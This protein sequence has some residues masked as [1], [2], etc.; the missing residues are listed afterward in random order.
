LSE[1][2]IVRHIAT[3]TGPLGACR[4]YLFETVE[5]LTELGIRDRRLETMAARVREY[6]S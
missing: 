6:R 4:E 2:T 5:H 1:N 3:A